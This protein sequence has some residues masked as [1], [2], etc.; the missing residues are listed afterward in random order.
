MAGVCVDCNNQTHHLRPFH[1]LR[2]K[3]LPNKK[4]VSEF[5]G[6]WKPILKKIQEAPGIPSKIPAN[7]D[8]KLVK[9]SFAIA[10]D[11]LKQ[12]VSYIWT[13]AKNE[14]D[15]CKYRIGTWSKKVTHSEIEKHGNR[16]DIEKLP[17][18]SKRNQ[19]HVNKRGGWS[20]EKS[21]TIRR[22]S[23]K[24]KKRAD[25]VETNTAFAAAFIHVDVTH[26]TA[27]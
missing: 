11:Y 1:L 5:D 23:K 25:L 20:I 22:V 24:T 19:E 12:N 26:N 27:K 3:D 10:T 14:A 9:E 18:K 8:E 2:G 15:L 21:T 16:Q 13:K 7:T 4:L 17:A 6:K